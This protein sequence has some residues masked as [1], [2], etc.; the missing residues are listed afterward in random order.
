[1]QYIFQ[2]QTFDVFLLEKRKNLPKEGFANDM[3]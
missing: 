3:K 2:G 1:M